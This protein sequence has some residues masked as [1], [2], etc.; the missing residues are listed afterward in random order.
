MPEKILI[1]TLLDKRLL[2]EGYVVVPF[3][4]Q[5][6]ITKLTDFFHENHP[7]GINGFYATAHVQDIS[8]R[9]KMNDYIK[10][11][12]RQSVDKYFYKCR[13]LGG[14]FVVKSNTQKERLHPHQ[15]WN[16][17]DENKHRSFN[18]WVPLVDLTNENGVIKVMPKSH[19][20][21]KT[22]RG[23]GLPDPFEN[24]HEK[25]WRSMKPLYMKGGEALIY[26]HRL[27]HASDPNTIDKLRLAAVFGIISDNV[28]MYYYCGKNGNLEVYES[29][30]E[31]FLNENIQR[32]PEVLKKVSS[33][34]LIDK[35]I[36]E[37][38]YEWV[39]FKSSIA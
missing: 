29:S 1:D 11:S 18:I 23:P 38:E 35:K 36:G 6:E 9:N 10:N 31:F 20:W 33:E 26:D 25:I 15:D 4:E 13:P 24:V 30:P 12:F 3:L 7:D 32:G 17:V 21:M 37:W 8:F 5:T 39:K 28:P 16:I 34:K 2:K 22:F 19:R 27:F 14:S